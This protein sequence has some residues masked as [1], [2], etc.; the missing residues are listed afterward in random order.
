MANNKDQETRTVIDDVND[1]LTGVEQK[2]VKNKKAIMWVCVGAAAVVA[3]VLIYIFG[4]RKPA[5]DNANNAIAQADLELLV[6]NDS[7][8][9]KQYQQVANDYGHDAGNRA[10]LQSAILLYDKGEYENALEYLKKYSGKE[11]LIGAT[12]KG[13]EGDCY[14]NLDKY[15]EALGCFDQAIKISDK[16]PS[17][18]PYFYMKKANVYNAQK[19]YKAEAEAYQTII[20]EYPSFGP[21]LNIDFEK[22]LERAKTLAGE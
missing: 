7:L 21:Q 6:G 11:S 10:A 2:V 3:V 8:A 18:T 13:L 16:N 19:N 1:S 12:A 5:I 9:L 4:I 20:D 14:V 15:D 22:Y 17:L